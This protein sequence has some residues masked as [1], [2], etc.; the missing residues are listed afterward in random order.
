MSSQKIK[1]VNNNNQYADSLMIMSFLNNSL[2]G[3]ILKTKN[4][5]YFII[6]E[7]RER[8][9]QYDYCSI[10]HCYTLYKDPLEKYHYL[11]IARASTD[12]I[13]TSG[14]PDTF[15]LATILVEENFRDRGI[16]SEII[17]FLQATAAERGFETFRLN[18]IARPKP[19]RTFPELTADANQCFYIKNGFCPALCA[20][21]YE[22]S[23]TFVRIVKETDKN[24]NKSKENED[25]IAN[26]IC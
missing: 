10:Y 11:R 13:Y 7:N 17:R 16:G 24:K 5:E 18:A 1:F 4:D 15:Y 26:A 20:Q 21:Q 2:P 6:V 23:T 3:A 25:E 9:N 14:E 19:N 22:A 8:I 12:E